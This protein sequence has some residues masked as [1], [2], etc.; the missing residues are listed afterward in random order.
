MTDATRKLKPLF[1]WRSAIADS[2]LP[3]TTRHCLLALSTYMNERGGSA[4]PGSTRLAHDTG[5][6]IRTV[7]GCLTDAVRAGWLQLV[8]RGGAPKDGP[9][10]ASVYRACVPAGVT[11]SDPPDDWGSETTGGPDDID[12]WPSLPGP[13][14]HGHPNSPLNSPMNSRALEGKCG[15][16]TPLPGVKPP[17]V[18][19]CVLDESHDGP[20]DPAVQ[21]VSPELERSDLA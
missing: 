11:E 3:A 10:R 21:P 20:C 6:H 13:V 16:W 2:D 1:T 12:Q 14:V 5:L 8:E 7:K 4:F 15:Q 19:L 9:R 17:T 18:A